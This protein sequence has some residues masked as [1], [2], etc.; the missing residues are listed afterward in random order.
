VRVEC[1]ERSA[2]AGT[3]HH[4]KGGTVDIKRPADSDARASVPACETD[5]RPGDRRRLTR[6]EAHALRRSSPLTPAQFKE[7]SRLAE[8]G[9]SPLRHM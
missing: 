5:P 6:A 4:G 8:Q 9:I 7:L 2:P 3:I 1:G